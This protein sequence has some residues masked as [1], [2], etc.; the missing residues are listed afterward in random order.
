MNR[1]KGSIL[2]I[3][4]FNVYYVL[5]K[6]SMNAVFGRDVRIKALSEY[7]WL[8][9]IPIFFIIIYCIYY[10][11]GLIRNTESQYGKRYRYIAVLVIIFTL[12]SYAGIMYYESNEVRT[13]GIFRIQDKLTMEKE[14]FFEIDDKIIKCNRNEFNMINTGGVYAIQYHW[15]NLVPNVG[16]LIFIDPIE[17]D[18]NV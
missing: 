18:D 7:V 11:T 9:P 15:N 13:G 16:N 5:T 8:L 2:I 1:I 3:T 17:R 6:P 4:V 10:L 14:Y 12:V